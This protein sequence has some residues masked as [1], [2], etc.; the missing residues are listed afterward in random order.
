[1]DGKIGCIKRLREAFG[2]GLLE[3]KRIADGEYKFTDCVN[4]HGF[5]DDGMT[6]IRTEEYT[7]LVRR[8]NEP[9]ARRVNLSDLEDYVDASIRA[10]KAEN[11]EHRASQNLERTRDALHMLRD[12]IVG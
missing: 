3:A 11:A 6:M 4:V 12:R 10:R 9:Q 7:A 2:L 8:A 5:R 1:M